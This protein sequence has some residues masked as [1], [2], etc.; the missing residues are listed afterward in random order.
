MKYGKHKTNGFVQIFHS[1]M[2]QYLLWKKNYKQANS[3]T[4]YKIWY[5][6]GKCLTWNCKCI[7]FCCNISDILDARCWFEWTSKLG[8]PFNTFINWCVNHWGPVMLSKLSNLWTE[9]RSIHDLLNVSLNTLSSMVCAG[10]LSGK[11]YVDLW[12][13][14]LAGR[15][16]V[17]IRFSITTIRFDL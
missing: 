15:T 12:R 4:F 17:I 1:V 13:V 2:S 7:N 8:I 5:K 16:S 6:E 14:L 3:S 10:I 11:L 9:C